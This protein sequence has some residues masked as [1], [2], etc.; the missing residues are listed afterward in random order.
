MAVIGYIVW[1]HGLTHPEPQ[2]VFDEILPS[3]RARMITSVEL[4]PEDAELARQ[5]LVRLQ[6][7]AD[8]YSPKVINDLLAEKLDG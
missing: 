4:R 2:V 3:T 6:T 1:V 5:G 7:L 8:H